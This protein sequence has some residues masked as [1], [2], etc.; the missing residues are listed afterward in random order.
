MSDYQDLNALASTGEDLAVEEIESND[1]SP[2]EVPAPGNYL[3]QTREIRARQKEDG[4]TTFEV[5]FVGGLTDPNT[6]KTI[7]ASRPEKTYLSTKKYVRTGR[8]GQTSSVAEYLRACGMDPKN[9]G[10]LLEALVSSQSIPLL[11]YVA[12]E[13]KGKKVGETWVNKGLKTRDF[14]QGSKEEPKYVPQVEVDGEVFT[15]RARATS[16]F[17][18]VR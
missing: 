14:N 16:S 15:A 4:S 5:T 2:F 17:Q 7:F 11:V 1:Y 3:S 12:W 10:N 18:Q 8:P 6:G 9:V 13:D